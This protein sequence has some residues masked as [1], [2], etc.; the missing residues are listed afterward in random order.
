MSMDACDGIPAQDRLLLEPFVPAIV[1][2][3]IA[4]NPARALQPEAESSAG[5]LL[6]ADLSGFCSLAESFARR[7]PRG[8]EDL[9]DVLNF[10]CGHLVD[11]VEAHGGEVLNFAGDAAL[12]LWP[13]D[14]RDGSSAARRAAQCAVAVQDV[15]RSVGAPNGMRLNLRCG[16]GLGEVWSANV[17]GVAGRWE[18][19]VAGDPLTQAVEAMAAAANGDI[20]V[21][22]AAWACIAPHAQG[23][24][25]D[26]RNIRLEA[27]TEP[28][29]VEH[30][31]AIPRRPQTEA[32]LRAYVPPS[33]Q[34]RL[35]ARQ[36]DWLA[37]FRRVTALF[38][39]LGALTY[40]TR[41]A[42]DQLQRAA[43]AVQTA[44]YRHG[45]SINQLLV[46][47]KGTVVVCGWGLALH[48]HS[49]DQVR[50]VR[51]AL[52]AHDN[53]QEVGFRASF[54]LA[55]G[56]VFTGLLGNRRR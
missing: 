43:V 3:R 23:S 33:V 22:S 38:I 30:T 24:R 50:A 28:V 18:F 41:E 7:G 11:L 10:F 2:R 53:L 45:G 15:F 37:E 36:S 4:E 55:T 17:G 51:A 56:D 27:V 47:D 1:H 49:D 6:L 48:A 52:E 29:P 40:G 54:G 14:E 44:V 46:D 26:A 12:A 42:L 35:D 25:L 34:A 8:A 20:A 31:A 19:L 13:M 16:L 32:V 9:S 5:V 39:K 21:S